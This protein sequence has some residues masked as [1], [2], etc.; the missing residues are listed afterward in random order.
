MPLTG[1]PAGIAGAGPGPRPGLVAV[2]AP[3]RR[4]DLLA[5]LVP[6]G[7]VVALVGAGGKKSL[8]YALAR[9]SS[10]GVA[11][12]TTVRISPYDS[13][14]VDA[15]VDID[16]PAA[17]AAGA[18]RVV[19]WQG[20]L[21]RHGRLR[22]IPL[23]TL[24][25]LDLGAHFPLVL[26]KADGARG[27]L[28]KAP[29]AHEPVL[30]PASDHV[31]ALCSVRAVGRP[32]DQRIA[33][34]PEQ[35]MALTGARPGQLFSAGHLGQLIA[36][37]WGPLIEAHGERFTAIINMVDDAGWQGIALDAAHVAMAT[38]AGLSRVVLARALQGRV[39]ACVERSE[40]CRR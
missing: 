28:V 17:S 38:H 7:G 12:T 1:Q 27:R 4:P 40:L 11:L 6:G 26:V 35:V 24:A 3:M 36:R 14:Q 20:A 15:I 16:T 32:L 39:I 31:L 33:H 21:H 5:T 2:P 25:A 22:G 37:A 23:Q 9:A 34:R 29:A 18:G 10:G 13:R 8:M 30:P 19:A